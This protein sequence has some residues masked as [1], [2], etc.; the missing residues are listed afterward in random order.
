M[1]IVQPMKAE[2]PADFGCAQVG[3]SACLERLLQQH[4]ALIHFIVRRQWPG[5]ADYSDLIQEGR[6]GLWL[7][8]LRFDPERGFTFS[9][10][11]GRAIRN[12]VW[13]A[14]KQAGKV[15]GWLEPQRAGDSLTAILT[16]W[17]QEQLHQA[18]GDELSCLPDDLRQVLE[19]AFGL[20]GQPPLKLAAIG[21]QIGLTR[22]RVRQMRNEGLALLQLPAL[23]L[24]L[25][26]LYEQDSRIAY[27]QAR[28]RCDAAVCDR[29]RP[30]RRTSR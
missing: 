7:A 17:Q 27:R 11:A 9:T 8:I 28:R 15:E 4:Q 21:R 16:A 30:R 2:H 3:C 12:R 24:R 23:S 1:C 20:D 25:R 26:S 13:N 14:V 22:E 19:L 5:A 29:R 10:F 6:I 18:L